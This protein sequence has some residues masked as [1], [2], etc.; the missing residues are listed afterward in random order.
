MIHQIFF[1]GGF[2]ALLSILFLKLPFFTSHFR[3]SEND[4]VLLSA[5]FGLFIFLGVAQCVNSRTDRLN[6]FNGINKNPQDVKINLPEGLEVVN[7]YFG[8]DKKGK[9]D[10]NDIDYEEDRF[11][12]DKL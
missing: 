10:V 8:S 2:S 6:L 3:K 11:D 9:I 12:F 4:L 1:S 5:F 7:H